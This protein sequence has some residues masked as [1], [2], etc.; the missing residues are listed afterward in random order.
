MI[1]VVI[2]WTA[3]ILKVVDP[4]P[5]GPLYIFFD[6]R[7]ELRSG[8]ITVRIDDLLP[9][10]PTSPVGELTQDG[11]TCDALEVVYPGP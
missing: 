6:P 8:E 2:L 9:P 1:L 7:C 5:D 4:V 3:S 10:D 11:R